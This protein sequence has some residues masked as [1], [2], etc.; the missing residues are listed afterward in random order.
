MK[1]LTR[2]LYEPSEYCNLC[3]NREKC[4]DLDIGAIQKYA[5]GYSLRIIGGT[6]LFYLL[7]WF[8][9]I[10]AYCLAYVYLDVPDCTELLGRL[11]GVL[12]IICYGM[13]IGARWGIRYYSQCLRG[14]DE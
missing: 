5:W 1:I 3:G 4:K 11:F 13:L 7:L 14:K 6:F 10:F 9:I 12:F 8:C 2:G